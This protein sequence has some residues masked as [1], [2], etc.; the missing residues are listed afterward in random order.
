MKVPVIAQTE[1]IRRTIAVYCQGGKNV[2]VGTYTR[3]I[4]IYSKLLK[5]EEP[6]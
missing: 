5:L 2:P 6:K 4:N 1:F 3:L